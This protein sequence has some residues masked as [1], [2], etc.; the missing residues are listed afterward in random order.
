MKEDIQETRLPSGLTI[1]TDR[2]PGVR[3]A[4]LGF[5][6][7]KGA[8]DEPGELHGIS[9]FI[10]HTVFKGTAK[11][12]ALD[13]AIEQDR[14]G[15]NLDAFT[16]HEE[17]GFAIKVIDDQLPRAFDLIADMLVHPRFDDTDLKAEQKVIIEEMKMIEDSPEEYLGEIFSEA[18]F[19]DHPLGASIAGTPKTVRSFE[20]ET[21]RKYHN[22]VF[23]AAN[24]VIAAAGNVD[25]QQIVELATS[26]WSTDFSRPSPESPLKRGLQA[27]V[28]AA[29][30][31]IK[32]NSNLEQAHLIIATPFPSATDPGRYAA[33]VL[34]N[35][36]GGGTSSRLWQKVREERGLA[37]SVGASS[38]SY[39]DCGMFSIFAATSPD[40]VEEVVDL[41]IAEMRA[42]VNDGVT[43]DELELAKQQAVAS[44]LLSL[45]DSA[46]R[47]AAL[48][49]GEM[50]HGRQIPVEETLR[51]LDAV[52][53]D[54]I[55]SLAREFFRTEKI[56]FAAL[57]DLSDLKI[58]RGRLAI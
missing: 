55:H 6:F 42:V 21:T 52:T 44:I 38:I 29:P 13:I 57:G 17:T 50:T 9:H 20:S 1:L 30:I 36:I 8:R 23:N 14:L 46:S 54:D 18:F 53:T 10:E 45:E 16:T 40:Q 34:A 32:Q 7:R 26:V 48:A 11:R 43:G 49:Q 25:H 2:M 31:L 47:A 4:T 51:R 15:G 58:D 39:Q 19:P 22:E 5:F 41:S 12:S 33:D 35:I 28:T 3:S 37:Y 24:L 27:P 56:A